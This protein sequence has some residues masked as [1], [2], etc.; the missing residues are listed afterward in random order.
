MSGRWIQNPKNGVARIEPRLA[1]VDPF[2]RFLFIA[3]V[4]FTAIGFFLV[5]SLPV[6]VLAGIAVSCFIGDALIALK[7][8]FRVQLRPAAR[9]MSIS[10]ARNHR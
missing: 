4:M 3:P 10:S 9:V 1:M 2:D 8:L 7:Y 6:E 5:G